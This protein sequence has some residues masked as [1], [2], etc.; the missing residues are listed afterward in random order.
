L[1]NLI[2]G[3]PTK[4]FDCVISEKYKVTERIDQTHSSGPWSLILVKWQPKSLYLVNK[5]RVEFNQADLQL[6]INSW[7]FQ[8]IQTAVQPI[9]ELLNFLSTF[10]YFLI[11]ECKTKNPNTNYV[12]A[13]IN[14]G[15]IRFEIIFLYKI[16]YFVQPVAYSLSFIKFSFSLFC[17]ISGLSTTLSKTK[18]LSL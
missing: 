7:Y 9:F 12:H 17:L 5:I 18:I 11:I 2:I 14:R 4:F 8:I 15:L 16:I 1:Q 6:P 3:G 10:S 13:K